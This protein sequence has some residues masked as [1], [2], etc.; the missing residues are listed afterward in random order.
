MAQI[1]LLVSCRRCDRRT[2]WLRSDEYLL[3]KI[4]KA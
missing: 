1:S 3:P 4:R 2:R